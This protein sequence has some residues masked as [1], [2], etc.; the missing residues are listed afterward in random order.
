MV[1]GNTNSAYA[2]GPFDRD[3]DGFA[4]QKCTPDPDT[5]IDTQN[6]N[7]EDACQDACKELAE[8]NFYT[9]N[10][11][12]EGAERCK[13]YEDNY[14]QNCA[15]YSGSRETKLDVCIKQ[16]ELFRSDCDQFVM[17]DCDYEFTADDV[18]EEA[19]RGSIVDA[20]HCQEYCEIFV[21]SGC[22][23]WVFEDSDTAPLKM[24]TCKL[25]NYDFDIN[26]CKVHHGPGDQDAK[27]FSESCEII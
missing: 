23:Y 8:C 27:T 19:N 5:F 6:L 2:F 3:C 12:A 26:K 25:Y 16:T 9:W 1:A 13:L 22:N 15:I 4:V 11:N 24:S 10:P 14:R 18:V 17:I 20:Y 21:D 7:N